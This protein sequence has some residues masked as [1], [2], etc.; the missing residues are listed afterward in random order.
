LS[1]AAQVETAWTTAI[2]DH[3]TIQAIT[4]NSFTY[5]VTDG[6]QA[7]I[8]LLAYAQRINYI[9]LLVSRAIGPQELGGAAQAECKFEVEIRYTRQKLIE[10]DTL[11][12]ASYAAVS[13]FFDTVIGLVYSQLGVSWSST[14]DFYT[15]Q[16]GPPKVSEVP[17]G[18]VP[19]WRGSYTFTGTQFTSL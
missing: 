1:T 4:T 12:G 19:C 13:D 8:D 14:V 17:V 5:E 10:G 11:N 9:E 15:H 6:S 7:E 18:G 16:D 3:A 2:L